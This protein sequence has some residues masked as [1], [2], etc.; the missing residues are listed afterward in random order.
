MSHAQLSTAQ[1]LTVSGR[2]LTL[3]FA[4]GPVSRAFAGGVGVEVLREA[5]RETL[6]ADLDVVCV[7]GSAEP[8]AATHEP[9]PRTTGPRYDAFA[10]GDEAVAED[11]DAPAPAAAVSGEDAALRLVQSELGGRVVGTTGE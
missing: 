9:A 8:A 2:T 6:G 11:P 4:N 1:V 7:V 10:P 5:L 3:S